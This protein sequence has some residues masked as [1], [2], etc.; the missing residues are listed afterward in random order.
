[1]G[2]IKR[3]TWQMDEYWQQMD[4]GREQAHLLWDQMSRTHIP[5]DSPHDVQ[6]QFESHHVLFGIHSLSCSGR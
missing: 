4:G 3:G 2:Q 6:W 5:P 1:M